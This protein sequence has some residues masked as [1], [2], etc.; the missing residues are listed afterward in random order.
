MPEAGSARKRAIVPKRERAQTATVDQHVAPTHTSYHDATTIH[1]RIRKW[2][3]QDVTEAVDPDVLSVRSQSRSEVCR[4]PVHVHSS[5]AEQAQG[6]EV[7][8]TPRRA[9]TKWVQQENQKWVK[10]RRSARQSPGRSPNRTPPRAESAVKAVVKEK[11]TPPSEHV[12]SESQRTRNVNSSR[13]EREERRRR[14][15]ETRARADDPSAP[16]DHAPRV[17][18]RS[19]SH[20]GSEPGVSTPARSVTGDAPEPDHVQDD[21]PQFKSQLSFSHDGPLPGE[22]DDQLNDDGSPKQPTKY[23]QTL[24]R[25]PAPPTKADPPRSRKRAILVKTKEMLTG[26][27]DAPKAPSDRIPSIRAWLDEQPDMPDPFVD[28]QPKTPSPKRDVPESPKHRSYHQKTSLEPAVVRVED[29]NKIWDSLNSV[30]QRQA[31]RASR[32][33]QREQRN[34][35]S[36]QERGSETSPLKR[37]LFSF[38][39]CDEPS[40]GEDHTAP[41]PHYAEPQ[42]EPPADTKRSTSEQNKATRDASSTTAVNAAKPLEQMTPSALHRDNSIQQ[43]RDISPLKRR[44]PARLSDKALAEFTELDQGDVAKRDN[45]RPSKELKRKL[46]THEDLLSVLSQPRAARSTRSV[47][48]T[49]KPEGSSSETTIREA[50]TI[51]RQEESKYNRELRTLVDGVTPVL[52]QS[53]L[54]KADATTT[55]G[56]FS[57]NKSDN[58]S[59]TRPIIDMGVALQ[60]L[61]NMHGRM[62]LQENK[63]DSLLTWAVTA[64]K[65]YSD[66]VKS[67]RLGFQGVIVN[68]APLEPSQTTEEGMLS[69]DVDGDVLDDQGQKADVAYL[70]KRP[71]V[72]IKRLAKLFTTIRDAKPGHEKASKV[73]DLY[74]ALTEAAKQRHSEEQ[75]RLEDEAAANIDTTRARNMKTMAPL[76]VVEVDK[77]RKVRARDN[78]NMSLYHSNGQ[79]LD[80]RIE[81]VLR[82]DPAPGTGGDVLICQVEEEAKWLLFQPIH[83]S[84]IS[85]RRDQS[86]AD[87][88]IMIKGVAGIAQGWHE[89][90]ALRAEDPA[91]ATEW[92]HMLGSNP[93]PPKL[94]HNPSWNM[95]A[96]P[97]TPPKVQLEPRGSVPEVPEMPKVPLNARALANLPSDIDVPIGEPSVVLRRRQQARTESIAKTESTANTKS[98]SSEQKQPERA[99]QLSMGGGL[100]HRHLPEGYQHMASLPQPRQYK[101]SKQSDEQPTASDTAQTPKGVQEA[102]RASIPSERSSIHV[103]K[104]PAP[105]R[106]VPLVP[107]PRYSPQ[108]IAQ[109]SSRSDITLANTDTA[110]SQVTS[111]RASELQAETDKLLHEIETAQ[112]S[113]EQEPPLMSG[114]LLPGDSRQTLTE[115][116][117]TGGENRQ[118]DLGSESEACRPSTTRP[119]KHSRVRSFASTPLADTM[120]EQWSMFSGFRKKQQTTSNTPEK[121]PTGPDL[122]TEDLPGLRPAANHE[123]SPVASPMVQ[124][125]PPPPPPAH[126]SAASLPSRPHQSTTSVP[127]SPRNGSWQQSELKSPLKHEYR[128]SS[129]DESSSD[130]DSDDT[131]ATSEMSEDD[132]RSELKD[133]A[134]PLVRVGQGNRRSSFGP[135][136]P[137][138]SVPSTGTKTLDPSDSASNGPYRRAPRPDA[139]PASQ[140]KK[141]IA[142]VCSWS[143]RGVWEPIRE[144]ECSIVISP[145]LVQAFPM[146]AAHSQPIVDAGWEESNGERPS[147]PAEQQPLVEFELTPVVPLRKGTALDITIRS[148]PTPNSTVRTTNNV[149]FRSRTVQECE[150]LYQLINWARCNN[151]TYAQLARSRARQ[152]SVTFAADVP[153]SKSRSWFSFGSREK[154]SYRASSRPPTSIA[155]SAASGTSTNSAFSALKKFG[156]NSP[157][158]LKRSSVIRKRGLASA[159]DSLYSSSNGGSGSGSS[160]PVPASQAGFVPGPDGPNVPATSAEA[161]NGGGMV[162]NMKIRLFVRKGAKWEAL[163]QSLLTVLPAA[164]SGSSPDSRPGSSGASTPPQSISRAPSAMQQPR[165]S[166]LRLPSS[167]TTPHRIHGDGREKRI[168][169][170]TAKNKNV[171][172]LDE[173]L[174]ESCFEKVM[175]TGIAVNVWKEDDVINEYGGVMTGRSRMYMIQ[176]KTSTEASWV[177][178]MCGTY[179]Y[180]NGGQP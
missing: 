165:T 126:R 136:R 127:R 54:S 115:R 133:Q 9:S 39:V 17:Y 168:L 33:E 157:F 128:G 38:E 70:Q 30:Q 97:P 164:I 173:I 148:P 125:Q 153:Q 131:D 48:I 167:S 171:V 79:R 84:K 67:W 116:P 32:R 146:S 5:A 180:G 88:V 64:H 78:F 99:S 65:S 18:T 42:N 29:P 113:W 43:D 10:Q 47:H 68:L 1:D 31:R 81:I 152:S 61:K 144:D 134:T 26:G 151:P 158:S 75:G 170:T 138:P 71:L 176:F 69:R 100:Q 141:T 63:I 118:H 44:S 110:G 66:Y 169:V 37:R 107:R 80:C 12:R 129:S 46:T 159:G 25:P 140:K 149:M 35:P 102:T 132:L 106:Q 166:H 22:H 93:L 82:D 85:S 3:T 50:L 58:A 57:Q 16:L 156:E 27:N 145:G 6:K 19:R 111:P 11:R 108:K 60:R 105:D 114:G 135:A 14:R 28:T 175:Q 77:K 96:D 15:R 154:S 155:D 112:H 56:L 109:P 23:A 51:M 101:A 89:L 36:P 172:L 2:Q 94:N 73:A 86:N 52:L 87:L 55:A 162:N 137:L 117:S 41:P 7:H 49:R 119:R 40:K 104:R 174:G 83:L 72:R 24:G 150:K 161:A 123:R 179:R 120:R 160:T 143:D 59:F 74:A 76:Q 103:P 121:R 90:L 142:I 177:F 45:S 130:T 13:A 34:A 95:P 178:N 122:L 53:L 139:F 163:G 147:N 124:E 98:T 8:S 62:P 21:F 20:F 92:L 4:T 91:A